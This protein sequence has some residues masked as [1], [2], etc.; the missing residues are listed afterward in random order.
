MIPAAARMRA[1]AT[2]DTPA[3]LGCAIALANR[4]VCPLIRSGCESVRG[5]PA[6]PAMHSDCISAGGESLPGS[7]DGSLPYRP[8]SILGPSSIWGVMSSFLLYRSGDPVHLCRYIK[9]HD[10]TVAV[11]WRDSSSLLV[12]FKSSR[13]FY[14]LGRKILLGQFAERQKGIVP[15]C[16]HAPP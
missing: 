10:K 7:P 16:L 13:L 3:E 14:F 2:A 12:S 8:N 4:R 9:R 6:S 1:T 15:P 5:I 11:P